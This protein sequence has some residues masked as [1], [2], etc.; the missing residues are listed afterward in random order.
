MKQEIRMT[1]PDK[2][3]TKAGRPDPSTTGLIP[4]NSLDPHSVEPV[5]PQPPPYVPEPLFNKRLMLAW[6]MGAAAVWFTVKFVVPVAI[7]SAKT[8]VV[9]SVKEVEA[10]GGVVRIKIERDKNGKIYN[11]TRI[12]TPAVPVPAK[13][14]AAAGSPAATPTLPAD[15]ATAQEPVKKPATKK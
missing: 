13:A 8:A 10:N 3:P 5:E 9:E 11:I 4:L 14:P 15:P 2:I 1:N 12:E 6:A 7:D